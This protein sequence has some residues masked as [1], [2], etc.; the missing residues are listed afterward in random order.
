MPDDA[1][2]LEQAVGQRL[3]LA[4][5]GKDRPSTEILE[6]LR[7]YRPAGITL[8]RS[9]N[10][11]EPSQVLHLTQTLQEAARAAG[12]PPLL[13]AADQ[14]GG[15]LVA[16]GGGTTPLP[17]NLALGAA[18]SPDLSRQAGEV[19][20][21]ELAAMGINVNYA[22]CCDV[23]AN[24]EN[25]VVG[26]RS[27]GED[28]G[29]VAAMAAA[30]VKGFQAAGVAAT[31]KHFPGHGDTPT[32]SHHALPIVPHALDRLRR[33]ELPPFVACIDAGVRLVM[34][35]H[36]ALPAIDGRSDLPA[37]QSAAIMQGLLRADLGFAGV[38]I[39]DAME[40]RA[41]P[42]SES[43]GPEAVRA[44]AA[45]ADL[46][47]LNADP[48]DQRLVHTSLLNALHQ[49]ILDARQVME[50][51]RRIL[52]LKRW[53]ARKSPPP[54]LGV[55]GC[56]AHQAVARQIAE[57]SVTLVRDRTG[58]RTGKGLLPLR[59][60]SSQRLAVILPQPQDLTPADTSSSVALSLAET[61]RCFH[62][63]VDELSVPHAPQDADISAIRDKVFAYDLLIVGTLNAYS[64]PGQASLVRALLQTGVP[65]IVVALRMPYDLAAFPDAQTYL[66]TYSIQE[67]SLQALAQGLFGQIEFQGR[68]PVTI[69]GLHPAG[70]GQSIG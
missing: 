43:L 55:V 70:F 67:P 2:T 22:P 10:L 58:P 50:S 12:L 57:R 20:G 25:S 66:C 17:G 15:Q 36:L 63:S 59:L 9:L 37:T 28:P 33:V 56:A 35:G 60:E 21:R 54:D 47:L 65:T 8:F 1:L 16:I 42:Q 68:L 38:I 29:M 62:Q 7:E 23:I 48:S 45:G 51:A 26:T 13:I 30:Q 69:P 3:L 32:D 27:F 6:A 46:L 24:P 61:L 39:T 40:M 34:T 31:A 18:G 5:S 14:E 4:F 64:Q 53:L 44:A 41:I 52:A 19:L 11:D 49:E